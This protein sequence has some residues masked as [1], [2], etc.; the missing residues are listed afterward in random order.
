MKK[1]I[2]ATIIG[3]TASGVAFAANQEIR[4]GNQDQREDQLHGYQQPAASPSQPAENA[5]KFSNQD[6]RED[7][8]QGYGQTKASGSEPA[9]VRVGR[10]NNEQQEDAVYGYKK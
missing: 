9:T 2:I 1:I 10:A 7:Q 4:Y 6:A 5:S 8:L 3:L